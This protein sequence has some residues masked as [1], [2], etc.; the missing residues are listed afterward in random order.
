MN[1]EKMGIKIIPP[2]LIGENLFFKVVQL[3]ATTWHTSKEL[4]VQ[5]KCI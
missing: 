2:Y 4:G 5:H 3:C 1:F